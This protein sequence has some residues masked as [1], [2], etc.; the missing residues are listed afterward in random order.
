MPMP[1]KMKRRTTKGGVDTGRVRACWKVDEDYLLDRPSSKRGQDLYLCATDKYRVVMLDKPI[2]KPAGY[3]EDDKHAELPLNFAQS[4]WKPICVAPLPIHDYEPDEYISWVK[5]PCFVYNPCTCQCQD[6]SAVYNFMFPCPEKRT[7]DS[8]CPEKV[9]DAVC[10]EYEARKKVSRLMYPPL[11]KV[12]IIYKYLVTVGSS[13]AYVAPFPPAP[14]IA[15]VFEGAAL[16]GEIPRAHYRHVLEKYGGT[17]PSAATLLLD[18]LSIDSKVVFPEGAPPEATVEMGMLPLD[19]V[20]ARVVGYNFYMIGRGKAHIVLT[21]WYDKNWLAYA[22]AK[23]CWEIRK[24]V[25]LPVMRTIGRYMTNMLEMLFPAE[26]P[27]ITALHE[28]PDERILNKILRWFEVVDIARRASSAPFRG[29][30]ENLEG[31]A[32]ETG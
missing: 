16:E 21:L 24:D 19:F 1:R 7:G 25:A 28:I 13:A 8:W 27:Q 32:E 6:H 12:S 29:V 18:A 30:W 20:A 17:V 26:P 31:S 11:K 9:G 3:V 4:P 22:V 5:A 14:S 15:M 10:Y 2:V 23:A